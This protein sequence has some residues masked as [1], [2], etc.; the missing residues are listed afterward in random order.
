MGRSRNGW[1]CR[2]LRGRR[3]LLLL[4]NSNEKKTKTKERCR[5]RGFYAAARNHVSERVKSVR[6][7]S[8]PSVNAQ[9]LLCYF[10]IV[11]FLQAKYCNRAVRF[12]VCASALSFFLP[13]DDSHYVHR[14]SIEQAYQ[15]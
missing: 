12:V 2:P 9:K 6:V 1:I 5:T 8:V 13:L 11:S 7:K 3:E 15:S 14:V 10:I 4:Y